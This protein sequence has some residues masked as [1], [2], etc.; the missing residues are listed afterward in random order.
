MQVS[1]AIAGVRAQRLKGRAQ[2]GGRVHVSLVRLH[3]G[4]WL[5]TAAG[6]LLGCLDPVLQI[7]LTSRTAGSNQCC[8]HD[9]NE[10]NTRC[11]SHV[12][13]PAAA[14]AVATFFGAAFAAP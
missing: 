9:A 13:P 14:A 1:L 6:L 3:F 5:N 4:Q 12:L 10:A 2:V 7:R 11:L 8:E